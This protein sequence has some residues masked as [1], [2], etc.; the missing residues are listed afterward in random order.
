MSTQHKVTHLDSR[1]QTNQPYKYQR[2]NVNS[3]MPKI[4]GEHSRLNCCPDIKVA[5]TLSLQRK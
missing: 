5:D 4:K 3:D 2:S 1:K